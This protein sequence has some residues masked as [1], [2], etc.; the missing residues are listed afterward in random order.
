MH[1]VRGNL[2]LQ[3]AKPSSDPFLQGADFHFVRFQQ[4]LHDSSI[5]RHHKLNGGVG[6]CIRGLQFS[7]FFNFGGIM[8]SF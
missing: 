7:G 8:S 3:V 4:I 1:V 2:I 6:F 5:S